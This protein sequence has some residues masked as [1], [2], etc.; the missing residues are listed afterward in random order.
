MGVSFGLKEKL[1][2]P[3]LIRRRAP[4]RIYGAKAQGGLSRAAL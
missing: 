2:G 4:I 3:V 1:A